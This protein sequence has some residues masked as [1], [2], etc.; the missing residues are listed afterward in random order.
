MHE[1]RFFLTLAVFAAA[2]APFASPVLFAQAVKP[3]TSH[4]GVC[5]VSVPSNW[6]VN[7]MFG[8]ANSADNKISVTLTSPPNT[9]SLDDTKQ[10]APMVYPSDKV[11]K[12]TPS[13]FQMEGLSMNNKPNVYRGIQLPGKVCIVEVIYETGTIDDARKI[14][15]TLKP[16]K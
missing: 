6:T 1:K 4:N 13:E 9:K 10:M 7:T 8:L 14:V 16:A 5:Q 15:L 3:V 12:S 11:V 2:A